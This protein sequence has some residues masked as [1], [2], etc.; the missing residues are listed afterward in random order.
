MRLIASTEQETKLQSQHTYL[1]VFHVN[2][3]LVD[4][5]EG[6]LTR[7]ETMLYSTYP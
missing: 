7:L 2:N 1:T 4:G 6:L 3:N 5:W